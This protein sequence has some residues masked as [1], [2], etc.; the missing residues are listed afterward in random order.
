ME[1]SALKAKYGRKLV[2][3]GA[4]DSQLIIERTP[5]IV[6]AETRRILDIMMPGGGY[7]AGP[8]H[9]YVLV[10]TPVENVMALYETVREAGVYP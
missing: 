6:R 1:P 3:M 9:D 8:S 10:E 2:L 5:E 4:I 7:V